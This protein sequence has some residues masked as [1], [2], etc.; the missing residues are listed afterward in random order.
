ML[1]HWSTLTVP[2]LVRQNGIRNILALRGD[3]PKGSDTWEMCDDGWV[4]RDVAVFVCVVALT[5]VLCVAVGVSRFAH[6]VDLVKFI[7]KEHGDYFGI[8]TQYGTGARDTGVNG[9]TPP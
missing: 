2:F 7:R 4:P 3:P 5:R 1:L 8:G 6:A 9:L